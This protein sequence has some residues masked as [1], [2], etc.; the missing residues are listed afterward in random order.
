MLL[1][2]VQ[3]PDCKHGAKKIKVGVCAMDKKVS[4]QRR[5]SAITLL[6]LAD[7]SPSAATTDKHISSPDVLC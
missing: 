6:L 7:H 2:C 4:E 3:A 5:L 1:F